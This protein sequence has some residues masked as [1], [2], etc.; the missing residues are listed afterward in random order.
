MAGKGG[1][2]HKRGVTKRRRMKGGYYGFNGELAKGAANWKVSSEHG[3][4]VANRGGNGMQYGRGRRRGSR[5]TAKGKRKMKGGGSY[6][7]TSASFEGTGS[8]GMAD[9]V[10]RNTKGPAVGPNVSKFGAFNDNG[11]HKGN[12]GSFKSLLPK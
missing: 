9:V 2:S 12:W 7:A 11:A 3:D 4:M 10:S 5:K 8:R 6:G 1:S